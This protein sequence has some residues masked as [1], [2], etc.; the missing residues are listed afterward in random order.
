MLTHRDF[1]TGKQTAPGGSTRAAS[2]DDLPCVAAFAL[3]PVVKAHEADNRPD[4]PKVEY[5][6]HATTHRVGRQQ[7]SEANAVQA[8]MLVTSVLGFVQ[9]LW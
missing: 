1:V 8:V 5:T 7:Y 9:G 3:A 4:P 6:R 2:V